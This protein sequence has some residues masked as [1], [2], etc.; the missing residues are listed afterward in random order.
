MKFGGPYLYNGECMNW[1]E[2]DRMIFSMKG[3]NL[4]TS[5]TSHS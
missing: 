5:V 1:V 3:H 2:C 4:K